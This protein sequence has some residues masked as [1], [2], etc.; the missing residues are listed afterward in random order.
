M[1]EPTA[2]P[3]SQQLL[4]G[5]GAP[6]L[7]V[8]RAR[9]ED[10]VD[11]LQACLQRLAAGDS[12]M[13]MGVQPVIA[14]SILERAGYVET[15]PHLLGTVHTFE[16]DERLWSELSPRVSRGEDWMEHHEPSDVV[17][18]PAACYHVYPQLGG[19][20]VDGEPVFDVTGHC[21]RHERSSEPGRMR[22]FRMREL[23]KVGPPDDVVEWRDDWLARVRQWLQSLGLAV[24]VEAATDPFFGT[25]E[26]LMAPMQRSEQLKWELVVDVAPGLRQAAASSNYHK[27]HFAEAFDIRAGGKRAHTSCMAFG[28]ERLALAVL[29]THGPDPHAWPVTLQVS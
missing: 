17:L 28:L 4:R 15:F 26:R 20:D 18:L 24:T 21:Y 29:H 27:D 12:P 8:F 6:G 22:S 1:T 2:P 13:R 16:G 23:V 9:F 25:V 5:A 11:A 14:R 3:A 10:L 19:S 7:S